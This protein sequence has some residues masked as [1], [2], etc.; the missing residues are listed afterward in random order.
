MAVVQGLGWLVTQQKL[1]D[2]ME[3][4]RPPPRPL[5]ELVHRGLGCEMPSGVELGPFM[6]EL[7]RFWL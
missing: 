6:E 4:L 2:T 3:N 7:H 5:A 1:T